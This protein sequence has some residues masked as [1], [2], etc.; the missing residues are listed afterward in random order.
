MF[1]VKDYKRYLS[2]IFG[3]IEE[4][5]LFVAGLSFAK[6]KKSALAQNAVLKKLEN[7]G[8][9]VRY[10]PE[11]VRALRPEIPWQKII[12]SRNFIIHEYFGIKLKSVWNTVKEDL[13][14]FKK[15]VEYL[16]KK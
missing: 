12:D 16:L 3:D 7:I 15:A 13:P 1:M 10:L 9:G 5:E 2:Y 6:F 8:E 11:E 4:A 14:P